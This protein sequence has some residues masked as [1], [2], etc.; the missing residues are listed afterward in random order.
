MELNRRNFLKGAAVT[1]AGVMGVAALGGCAPAAKGGQKTDSGAAGVADDQ[2]NTAT[3]V[4]RKWAFEIPPAPIAESDIK[5]TIE[6]EIV[7]VGAGTA[8]LMTANSAAEAGVD[9]FIVSASTNP[10]CRGGSN[11]AVYCK[12][13]E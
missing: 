1:A 13:F 7:V 11:N 5:E 4:Q 3:T 8:G 12:A 6:A 9:T 10:T 2:Y